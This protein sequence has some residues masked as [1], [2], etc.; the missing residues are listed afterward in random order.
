[1]DSDIDIAVEFVDVRPSDDGYSTAYLRLV[2]HLTD[3]LDTTVDV[4]DVRSMPPRFAHAAFD[5]GTVVHGTEARRRQ[6]EDE[7][8]GD[9]VTLDEARTRVSTAVERMEQ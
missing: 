1:M 8:S 7:L 3:A 5:A 9:P 2:S 4:V 6:L